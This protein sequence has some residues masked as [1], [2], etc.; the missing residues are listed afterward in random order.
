MAGLG[1][2]NV[3]L[4]GRL[5]VE[6]RSRR[7]EEDLPGRQGRLLFAYLIANRNRPVSRGELVEAL[8]FQRSPSKPDLA[9]SALL[10]KLRRVLGDDVLQGRSELRM[11]LPADAWID[12]EAAVAAIHRAESALAVG[13]WEHAYAP[14]VIAR[15][16]ASRVFL[17][18]EDAPWI[19]EIRHALDRVLL[20][21]LECDAAS[22]LR[23]GGAELP[24]ATRTAGELIERAPYHEGGYR[25]LMEALSQ[26]GNPAEALTVYERL[27]CL[28]RDELGTI[29]SA[30]TRAVHESLLRDRPLRD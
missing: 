11:Q 21:A 20:R 12:L 26:S 16:V 6:L 24:I 8:W 9:L 30:K 2:T 10:S 19:D 25:L 17:P 7:L 4:C 1:T 29:P 28:L 13:D 3:Q 27:R 14:A 22:S 18:G 15:R 23:I 5:A